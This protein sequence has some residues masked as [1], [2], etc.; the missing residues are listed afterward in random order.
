MRFADAVFRHFQGVKG[1]LS[2]T[3]LTPSVTSTPTLKPPSTLLQPGDLDSPLVQLSD[4]PTPHHLPPPAPNRLTPPLRS[5]PPDVSLSASWIL[6]KPTSRQSFESNSPDDRNH[7]SLRLFNEICHSLSFP[8]NN[9]CLEL[10]DPYRPLEF[11][12]SWRSFFTFLKAKTF[13]QRAYLENI[14][15]LN[16]KIIVLQICVCLSGIVQLVCLSGFLFSLVFFKSWD[17]IQLT[18]LQLNQPPTYLPHHLH[19]SCSYPLPLNPF[20]PRS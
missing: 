17:W 4:N 9:V 5:Q 12:R 1:V 15:I 20:L 16:S 19:T 6:P 10:F 3:N 13:F 14:Y 2:L 18:D 11:L 7:V 8:E